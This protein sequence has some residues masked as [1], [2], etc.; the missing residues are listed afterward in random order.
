MLSGPRGSQ[1]VSKVLNIFECNST[2]IPKLLPKVLRY[3]SFWCDEKL[4]KALFELRSTE[5]SCSIDNTI[6]HW[7]YEYQTYHLARRSDFYDT[8]S[9]NCNT[10]TNKPTAFKPRPDKSVK[11]INDTIYTIPARLIIRNKAAATL[12]SVWR[13]GNWGA[14]NQQ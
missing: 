12:I 7:K 2:K 14:Q 9:C 13:R 3:Y 11:P 5:N 1:W 6:L 8:M 4:L 10:Q